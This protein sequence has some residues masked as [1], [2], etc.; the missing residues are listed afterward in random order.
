M[1]NYDYSFQG[2]IFPARKGIFHS[3]LL[4][5]DFGTGG[6]ASLQEDVRG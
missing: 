2:G 4:F 6:P 3:R 1:R 5:A